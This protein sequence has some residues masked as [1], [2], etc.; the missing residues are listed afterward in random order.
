MNGIS[1]LSTV[2]MRK[3][4]NNQSEMVSMLLFGET[5]S[6]E[7]VDADWLFVTTHSDG[8]QGYVNAKQLITLTELPKSSTP[9]TNFPFAILQ[10]T[11][12]MIMAPCGSSLPNFADG[13]CVI[14]QH[15]FTVNNFSS[16]QNSLDISFVAQQYLN[17]PYLWGGRSPFGIDCSGFSQAVY[18][19][20][21]VQLK[22]DAYQQAEMGTDVAFLEE[23]EPGDLAF[24]NNDESR[25]THVGIMLN[26]HTIIH[27]SG[28][29]RIDGMD[30][31]G[32][33]NKSTQKYSHRLR[34]IKRIPFQTT[35]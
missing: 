35:V 20:F 26:Q 4:P 16:D 31:H 7:I 18:K 12:G 5:C 24:F 22:R 2:P 10:H 15:V 21:G 19:C 30:T 11:E 8:Y 14:D 3:E 29:V 23:V 33:F 27:A 6:Y 9:V 13:K 1:L 32:I 25:I 28:K 34:L 17:V